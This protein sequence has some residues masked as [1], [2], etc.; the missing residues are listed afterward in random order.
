[1]TDGDAVHAG[2]AWDGAGF[3]TRAIHVGQAPEPGTGAI[4]T[5]LYLASTYAQASP[6]VTRGYAYSR[7]GNPTRRAYEDCLASLESG[8]R[9]FAF[10]SGLAATTTVL[11]LLS[12]GDHVIAC[13]DI[14]GG[15]MRLFDRV[16]ARFGMGF[17]YV[18]LADPAALTAA[19]RPETRMLWIESPTNPLLQ[20]LDIRALCERAHAAGLIVVVDNTFMSPY[21]Q[22]PLELG[23]DVVVHSTTKYI[24]GHSDLVG[25]AAIV[26]DADL[27]DRIAFLSNAMGGVQ[28][29][30]DAWLC[31]RSLKTLAVRMRAHE[32]NA[33]AVARFLEAHPGVEDVRYPG[34][35]SHPQH[36]LAQAQMHGFGGMIAARVRGDLAQA[37]RLLESVRVFTLAESLGGVESL[38][39]HPA[40]MT[41]A[42]MP[43]EVRR[44]NG[45]DDGL[46]R[47]S[48]GLEDADDLVAD[49]AQALAAAAAPA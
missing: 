32:A 7:S 47:I 26:R 45:I 9:G 5:P 14:Y 1:M 33:F 13:H 44:A 38:I 42:S 2:E 6:G 12:Q 41:H 19:L 37:T 49:L 16:L 10:A 36:A 35:P 15:S 28:A 17:D 8:T 24:G 18:D 31:L 20:L 23:A 11:G 40:I 3:A 39:E 21:F 29:T 4:N 27:G 34:L 43:A 22:R 30:F 46:L 25:G 48:V